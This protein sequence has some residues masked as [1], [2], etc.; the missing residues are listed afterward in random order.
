M[1]VPKST[2]WLSTVLK[3]RGT[4]LPRTKNRILGVLLLAMA[5]TL[6]EEYAEDTIVDLTTVPFT[7]TGVALSIFLG[8]RNNAAY[9][10]WWEGRK[11]WGGLVNTTRT[12]ARQILTLVGPADL[13]TLAEPQR[14]ALVAL[15]KEL[16]YRVIAFTHALRLALR[17]SDDLSELVPLLSTEEVEA[18]KTQANRPVAITQGT[19]ERLRTAY[20]AG[21]IHAMH[22]SVLEASMTSLTDLQGGCERIKSTPIPFS[23]TTLIHRI[24]AFYCYG[25]PFGLVSGV[26][27]FTPVVV[28]VVSYAFFGLDTV[29]DEIEQPFGTDAN[30]LPLSAISRMIE[31]NLRQRLGEKDLP[32]LLRPV[33]ELLL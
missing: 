21:L 18:L 1:M 13:G 4:E 22:L 31:V 15:R 19:A 33:D 7:L 11:L 17:D 32:P 8:F 16:V 2:S 20:D 23:Y 28:V 25:L 30:D 14:A 27:L 6:T 10:R 9:D 26:G 12:F 29:G 5:V 24:V 3:Y